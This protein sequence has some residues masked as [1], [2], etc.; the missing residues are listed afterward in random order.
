MTRSYHRQF[1]KHLHQVSLVL[2]SPECC[3]SLAKKVRQ[4]HPHWMHQHPPEGWE[5][6]ELID[7][8]SC[9]KFADA[10]RPKSFF[11]IEPHSLQVLQYR[12]VE[13]LCMPKVSKQII[14]MCMF[15]L[16]KL[17]EVQENRS[18]RTSLN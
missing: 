13:M 10:G 8:F 16:N 18:S 2:R 12:A 11:E 1:D 4:A 15:I 6:N 5:I 7:V 14:F 17:A 9:K 3:P